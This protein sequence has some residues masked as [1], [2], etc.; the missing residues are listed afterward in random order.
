MRGRRGRFSA[1]LAAFPRRFRYSG[2]L[3]MRFVHT[4]DWHVGLK[5]AWAGDSAPRIV[6]ARLDSFSN[7]G[8]IAAQHDAEFVLSPA[9]SSTAHAIALSTARQAIDII[10]S[11]PCPV[12]VIP[13]NHD[14]DS[15][16]ALWDRLDLDSLSRFR[17]L[18]TPEAIPLTGG[19][20]YPARSTCA[21]FH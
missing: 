18:R 19:T 7:V 20:L 14:Q 9:T 4:S 5:A 2:Y 13:G 8:R 6:Q 12:Y 10:E 11:F 15:P 3:P 21:G 17:L 1:L 16:C